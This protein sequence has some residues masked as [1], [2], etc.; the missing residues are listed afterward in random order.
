MGFHAEYTPI[1]SAQEEAVSSFCP[2]IKLIKSVP[3]QHLVKLAAPTSSHC[4]VP[5]KIITSLYLK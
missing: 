4:L 5:L 1:Y 2:T 3:L